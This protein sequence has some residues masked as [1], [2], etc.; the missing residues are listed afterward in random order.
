MAPSIVRS[1]G[2]LAE[3]AASLGRLPSIAVDTEA[4]S[5]HSYWHQTCLLQISS[6]EQDYLIDP[7]AVD[8]APLAALFAAAGVEKIMHA[9]ENDVRVLKRDFAFS[10]A[11]LFDTM[12]AARILGYPRWGLADLL[13]DAFGVTLD[14]KY[15]RYDWAQRPLPP[16]ALHYAAMD[17]HYLPALRE[18]L[19]RELHA[20]GHEEEAA[21]EFARIAA[22]PPSERGFDP[23]DFWRVKGA[24]DLEPA[25]RPILRE[26]YQ[27]RDEQARRLNRPP[28]RVMPDHTL[29]AVAQAGPG[30][31]Q[32]LAALP[33]VSPFI[34]QRYGRALLAAVQRAAGQPPIRAPRGGRPDEAA[35]ARYDALRA[36]RN[37]RAA[38]RKVEGDVIVGNS[39]LKALA[40]A[41]PADAAALSAGGLLGPWKLR[42]Y[43]EE[44]L[45]ALRAA[46]RR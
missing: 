13:R 32:A 5:L 28:F 38:Q 26:L 24:Y 37:A 8:P 46:P 19:G 30:T 11:N 3:A 9:G 40:A 6:A 21:E 43:G 22:T 10:F 33:G 12:V 20:G 16:E 23:D 14:K 15:Q 35:L 2:A 41:P 25:Q 29:I 42:T 39:V 7:L 31:Q 17:T 45:A 1:A 34:A 36:W 27:F 18:K 44:I 4:D